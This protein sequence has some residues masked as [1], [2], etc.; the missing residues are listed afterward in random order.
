[1]SG[2][3]R[4]LG[5]CHTV[6]QSPHPLEL[7]THSNTASLVDLHAHMIMMCIEQRL[8]QLLYFYLNFWR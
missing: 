7:S 5:R 6:M 2:M 1:M 3:V 4:R 8:P